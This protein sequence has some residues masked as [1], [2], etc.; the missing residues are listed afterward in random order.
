MTQ[1]QRSRNASFEQES[2]NTLC[3]CEYYDRNQYRAHILA[4]CCNCEALDKLCTRI[5]CCNDNDDNDLFSSSP[6]YADSNTSLK[7]FVRNTF[8][9]GS[10][11]VSRNIRSI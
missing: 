5:L 6:Q 4:C 8:F 3:F 7:S 10:R 1:R 11:C 2:D 9:S